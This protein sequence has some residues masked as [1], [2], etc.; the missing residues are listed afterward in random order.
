MQTLLKKSEDIMAEIRT[1]VEAACRAKTNVFGYGIFTHHILPVVSY[2]KAFAHERNANEEIVELAAWLHDYANIKGDC[3]IGEHHIAGAAE[4]E[5]I[6][7]ELN[8]SSEKIHH[9]KE[10]ILAHRGSVSVS[11]KSL[12]ALCLSDADALAH[13]DGIPS[14]FH[15][16]YVFEQKSV[17]EAIEWLRAKLERSWNKLSPE[18]KELARPKYEMSILLLD[19]K[20]TVV[21]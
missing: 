2:S 11:Q 5:K 8:Y 3:A 17:D 1:L 20:P 12:E 15:Y 9:V 21:R 19:N 14:L 13:F 7:K 6:L 10:C 4:A 16:L 18:A